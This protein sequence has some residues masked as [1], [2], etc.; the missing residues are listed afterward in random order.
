M[1]FD[2]FF[3]EE[4]Y[5]TGLG[6]IKILYAILIPVPLENHIESGGPGDGFP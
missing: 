2:H 4:R 5:D 6:C 1:S 3:C